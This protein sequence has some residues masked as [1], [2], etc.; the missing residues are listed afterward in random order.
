MIQL[1]NITM[2]YPDGMRALADISLFIDKGEFVFIVGPSG[3]GKSTLLRLLIREDL[4]TRGQIMIGGHSIT[5]L[6]TAQVA[7]LR[8]SIGVVF[9]DFKLLPERTVFEN[10][11][12][13]L[14]VLEFSPREIRQRVPAV[15][16]RVGL[17]DRVKAYPHHLSGGEQQRVAIARAV[18]N[19]PR[20][21]LAD[22]PTGNL[23][24]ANSWEIMNLLR[25]INRRG[26]TVIVATHAHDIVDV[27]QKRVIT[28]HAGRMVR[29]VA[30]GVYA[31]ES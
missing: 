14:E 25:D 2:V 18:V 23:D 30:R 12:F 6:R 7:A 27:M 28:L 31:Y 19:N 8:R 11:A 15:L 29:D 20:I 9:Q 10:V 22:E 3:A 4:P 5:R 16:R 17:A 13:A 1:H 21:V 26:T 24:P